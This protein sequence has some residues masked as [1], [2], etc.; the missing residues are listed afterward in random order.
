MKL[1]IIIPVYNEAKTIE[2]IVSRVLGTKINGISERELIICDDASMDGTGDIIK[3]IAQKHNGVKVIAKSVNEGKGAA[4]RS[5]IG[6]ITG[7]VTI[8]QDADLEY[9]PDDYSAIL[10]PILCGEADAV[11]GSRFLVPRKR[12]VSYF[13]HYIGNRVLTLASNLFTNLNLTDMETCYKA[14]NSEILKTIPIRSN[15]FNLEPEIT[16]KIAKRK[17]R[18][19]EVPINYNG[20]PYEDGKKIGWKDAVHALGTIVKFWVI[21]DCVITERRL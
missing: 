19:Y 4:I 21:D 20:R 12:R 2:E 17:L 14:F 5:M 11:Y 9:D 13:R 10:E 15:R 18:L 1:S 16:A 3:N 8:I 6:L 7:D